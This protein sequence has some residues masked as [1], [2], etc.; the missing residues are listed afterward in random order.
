MANAF[1]TSGWPTLL[2]QAEMLVILA[3]HIM[4]SAPFGEFIIIICSASIKSIGHSLVLKALA[5]HLFKKHG[6]PLV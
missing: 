2:I 4:G 5:T 6:H 3:E 1:K